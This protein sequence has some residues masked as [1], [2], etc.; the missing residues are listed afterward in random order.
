MADDPKR[1]DIGKP[2]EKSLMQ[3]AMAAIGV[4]R[5][6][7]LP[8]QWMGAGKP[9]E[10]IAQETAGRKWD[11]SFH[12]N[13]NNTPKAD[14]GLTFQML[15]NIADFYDPL[16]LVIETRKDQLASQTWTIKPK[17][18]LK[19]EDARSIELVAMF[20]NPDGVN[21]W[22][23]WL[24][25]IMED[26]LVLDAVAVYPRKTIGGRAFAFE[27]I[28]AATIKRVVD[29]AGRTPQ[30][31]APAYQQILKGMPASDFTVGELVYRMRNQRTNRAYG[32]SPVEQVVNTV[33]I[34]MNRQMSQLQYFTEG[35]I[36][37]AFAGL[38]NTWSMEQM[39]E[40]QD[41]FDDLMKGDAGKKRS[42]RFMPEETA[43]SYKETKAPPLKDLFDEW[44]MRLIC[45]AFSI[46]PT[47][48]IA[49]VNRSV[50]E[51]TRE[52]ALQEGLMP[53]MNWVKNLVNF[54]LTT[55]C[56]APDMEFCWEEEE[57]VGAVEQAT[58]LGIYVDKGIMDTDE[59]RAKIG[60]EPREKE[61]EGGGAGT[62]IQATA[63]NGTQITSML[64]I[65]DSVAG[66]NIPPEAGKAIMTAA[67]PTTDPA[68]IDSIFSSLKGFEKPEPVMP[69]AP[70][71]QGGKPIT[72]KQVQG[73]PPA[74]EGEVMPKEK[75]DKV[76]KSD[77]PDVFVDVGATTIHVHLDGVTK[78]ETVQ[79]ID[80]G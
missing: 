7:K 10:P 67:F 3:R 36:P 2:V 28:D 9:L 16:R 30:S 62:D 57:A 35:T 41:W 43:K 63:L 1:E 20:R 46:D 33:Q 72:G 14:E 78:S 18:K 24:R 8:E 50:A 59:A 29:D 71:D 4:L 73:A 26:L 39:K 49:Q 65:V 58:I 25:L 44:L 56:N 64:S 38:P 23:D 12:R 17:D 37:D 13:T 6:G 66:K 22:S 70:T 47:P 15:R 27:V 11:Y 5:T 32:F 31:P 34:G 45:Y 76:E 75:P 61:G 55:Y 40:F 42:V 80:N 53:L 52:Q 48:F 60:M 21:D 74:K 79:R 54:L 77:S 19:K 69:P 68:L 51:T